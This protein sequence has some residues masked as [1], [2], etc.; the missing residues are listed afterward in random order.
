VLLEW[1]RRKKDGLSHGSIVARKLLLKQ[2]VY[3]VYLISLLSSL[4]TNTLILGGLSEEGSGND[5]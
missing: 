5:V 2:C 1:M 4:I 3:L